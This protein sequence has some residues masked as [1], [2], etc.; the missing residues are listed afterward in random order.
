MTKKCLVLLVL[1]VCLSPF[2]VLYAQGIVGAG[3]EAPQLVSPVQLYPTADTTPVLLFTAPSST[4]IAVKHGDHIVGSG[5]GNGSRLTAIELT[6][7]LQPG[8]YQLHAY[9]YNAES[10]SLQSEAVPLPPIVVTRAPSGHV[11]VADIAPL[12][13]FVSHDVISL[14]M[15]HIRPVHS[16]MFTE[17]QQR[18]VRGDSD[19]N[20]SFTVTFGLFDLFGYPFTNLDSANVSIRTSE[21]QSDYPV[22]PHG[23]EQIQ[24]GVY[25]FEHYPVD[26]QFIDVL[27]AGQTI[28]RVYLQPYIISVQPLFVNM[29]PQTSYSLPTTV[30]ALMSDGS[31]AV[32]PVL[33]HEPPLDLTEPGTYQV[34]G[35]IAGYSDSVE[36]MITV[37]ADEQYRIILTWGETPL[38]LDS[39]LFG[40]LGAGHTFHLSYANMS[41]TVTEVTYAQLEHDDTNGYGPETTNILLDGDVGTFRFNVH[42]YSQQHQLTES[43]AT[44]VLYKGNQQLLHITVPQGQGYERYWN[45]FQMVGGQVYVI[46]RLLQDGSPF[47]ESSI[48]AAIALIHDLPDSAQIT[49]EHSGQIAAARAA[50]EGLQIDDIVNYYKLLEAEEALLNYSQSS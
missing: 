45:V 5:L 44:V 25:Q 32:V 43:D 23:I 16:P 34:L 22:D 20:G 47:T 3:P 26:E 46:D 14:L 28:G 33:W 18:W 37:T 7:P 50:L 35:T 48:N 10:P 29:T 13:P 15:Q 41:Y 4:V 8:Y 9:T 1:L 11:T 24:D 6:V 2:Q 49:P 39:H 21:S 17:I 42:Q 30:E 40:S 38:D 27:Y 36:L 31:T 19:G 12:L